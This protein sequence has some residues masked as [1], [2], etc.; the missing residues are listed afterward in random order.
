MLNRQ[1]ARVIGAS[2]AFGASYAM[3]R[4]ALHLGLDEIR[5]ALIAG[6]TFVLGGIAA[7]LWAKG[8]PD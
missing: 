5:C 3:Y 1:A 2:L 7:T 6:V 8:Y 4:T